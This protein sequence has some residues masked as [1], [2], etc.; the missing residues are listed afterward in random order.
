[1]TLRTDIDRF[2]TEALI[3]ERSRRRPQKEQSAALEE[4][5]AEW[6]MVKSDWK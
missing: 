6:D 5:R 3:P 1:M 4:L 2:V